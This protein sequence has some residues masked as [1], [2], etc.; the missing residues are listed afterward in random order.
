M[1]VV[2]IQKSCMWAGGS[3]QGKSVF[4]TVCQ[5]TDTSKTIYQGLGAAAPELR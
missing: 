5:E 4:H 1:P 2:K 3:V